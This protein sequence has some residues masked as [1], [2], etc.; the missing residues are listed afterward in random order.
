MHQSGYVPF[1]LPF[2]FSELAMDGGR[3]RGRGMGREL[4]GDPQ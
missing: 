1:F 3:G 4:G 2:A